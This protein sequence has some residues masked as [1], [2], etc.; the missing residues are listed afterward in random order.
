MAAE[1]AL[2]KG[3]GIVHEKDGL[4]LDRRAAVHEFKGGMERG[5]AEDQAHK[6]YVKENH[7]D[8][9]AHHLAGIRA[10]QAVGD[11]Q[12]ARKHGVLYDLHASG[13]GH[14]PLEPVHSEV[15]ARLAAN[16]GRHYRFKSHRGDALLLNHMNQIT[17]NQD[18]PAADGGRTAGWDNPVGSYGNDN[19]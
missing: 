13:A 7:L 4:D 17:K 11:M 8:A 2:W 3:R 16:V 19:L 6:D 5:A 1:P 14:N 18:R 9:A 15:E 10:A 12:A